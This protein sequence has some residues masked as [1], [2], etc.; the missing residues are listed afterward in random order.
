M[1]RLPERPAVNFNAVF[2]NLQAEEGCNILR[3][4]RILK[5]EN[6]GSKWAGTTAWL[7]SSQ[8][9]LLPPVQKSRSL[10]H[11]EAQS[12][13]SSRKANQNPMKLL[14]KAVPHH[15]GPW[16]FLMNSATLI[17]SSLWER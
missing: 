9:F 7:T 10:S 13:H 5:Y 11:H 4:L 8:K 3:A 15:P 6:L 17:L 1:K 12:G 2:L 14:L 16:E